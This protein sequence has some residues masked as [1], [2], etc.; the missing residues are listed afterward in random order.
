VP[1]RIYAFAKEL[2]F[3]NKQ[4]LDVCEAVNIKGKG[5]ALASLD[6]DE[7]AKIKSFLDGGGATAAEPEPEVLTPMRPEPSRQRKIV[8]L[9][10][11]VSSKTDEAPEPEADDE[12]AD[13]VAEPEV[14]EVVAEEVTEAPAE[15]VAEAPVEEEPVEEEPSEPEAAETVETPE[16]AAESKKKSAKLP[17]AMPKT[18]M[19]R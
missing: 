8:D 10:D 1:I 3:D 13:E 17:R 16:D 19:P 18:S 15:P 11:K 4:L 5:S 14:A 6:D 7:V 9:P 2:G 12:V